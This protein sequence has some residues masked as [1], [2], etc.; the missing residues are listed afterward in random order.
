MR[1]RTVADLQF[2]A[3]SVIEVPLDP[4]Y[5]KVREEELNEFGIPNKPSYRT[6]DVAKI[7]KIT[8]SAVQ[9]RFRMGWYRCNVTRDDAGR[10]IFTKEDIAQIT[11]TEQHGPAQIE[12]RTEF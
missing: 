12:K 11:A 2:G 10:R 7:L 3:A 1:S 4:P 5:R 8:P 9:W 6:A